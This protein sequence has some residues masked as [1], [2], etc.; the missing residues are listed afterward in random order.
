MSRY[1][2]TALLQVGFKWNPNAVRGF[3][4]SMVLLLV[5]LFVSMCVH[6]TTP[7][8]IRIPNTAVTMIELRFGDGDGTGGNKGN[9]QE[10]GAKQKGQKTS[11]PLEDATNAG[12]LKTS[13]HPVPLEGHSRLNPV[14]EVG[15]QGNKKDGSDEHTIGASDGRDE[16]TGLGDAG[17]GRG[18]GQGYG[19]D[20]GG[21]GNRTV[22]YKELPKKPPGSMDTQIRLRFV[23]APDG[24][25]TKV[26]P[27][28]RSGDPS[29]EAVAIKTMYKWRF[30]PLQ[31]NS[32][33]EGSITLT[34]RTS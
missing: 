16:G 24:R 15:G 1:D 22:L 30:N 11:N 2:D 32:D 33:M 17:R 18:S 20:W 3:I 27:Y 8:P 23:V 34:F 26:W 12:G 9:L 14:K 21:G 19:I 7:D 28:Q 29:I 31:T 4:V 25:V 10:E 5:V 13:T 6:P